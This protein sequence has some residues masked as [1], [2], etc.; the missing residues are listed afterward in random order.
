MG[1]VV[2]RDHRLLLV[3]RG[4]GEGV[5]RWSLPG[6]RVEPGE[7]LEEAVRREMA[8]ETGLDVSVGELCGVAERR[9]ATA[10]YVILDFWCT[11][12]ADSSAVAGD[13]A[14]AVLWADRESLGQLPLVPRLVEFLTCHGV[15]DRLR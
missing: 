1:A 12:P 14:T 4:Q 8:E 15:L 13:D 7:S 11:A 9:S 3:R 6:G 5:G 2:V 10:H